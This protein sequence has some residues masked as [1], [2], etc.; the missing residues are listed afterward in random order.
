MT[1]ANVVN[2]LNAVVVSRSEEMSI[3]AYRT[4]LFTRTKHFPKS[5]TDLLKKAKPKKAEP[6]RQSIEDQ[7]AMAKFVTVALGGTVH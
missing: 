6:R 7:L 3:L 1:A 2:C 5:E 4:A